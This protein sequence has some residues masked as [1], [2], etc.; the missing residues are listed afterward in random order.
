MIL[1]GLS[2]A[3]R[4]EMERHGLPLPLYDPEKKQGYMVFQVSVTEDTVFGGFQAAMPGSKRIGA[5][6]SPEEAMVALSVV[7]GKCPGT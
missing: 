5:G 3:Q 6:E 4:N 1:P 7:L 2:P